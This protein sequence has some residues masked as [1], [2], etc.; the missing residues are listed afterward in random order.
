MSTDTPPDSARQIAMSLQEA[1]RLRAAGKAGEAE[2]LC[3][4]LLARHPANANI[5]NSLALLVW[6]RGEMNE[7]EVLFRAAIATAPQQAALYNNLGGL[8]HK[9]GD[10]PGAEFAFRTAIALKPIYPEACYNLGLVLHELG[11]APEA[12]AAQRRAVALNP[13]YGEALVRI[14]AL[15]SEAGRNEEA[16]RALDRALALDRTSF[17]AHYYRGSVLTALERYEEA[18]LALNAALALRPDSHQAHHAY[19]NAL[20]RAGRESEALESYRKALDAAPEFLEAHRDYNALAWTM[21]RHDL[22]LKSYALARARA[23]ETPDLLLAEADQRLRHEEGAVAERLLCQAHEAAPERL[24]ITNALA[25]ALTMQGHFG[26]SIALLENATKIAPNAIYNHRDLA[27][28]FLQDGQPAQAR[29][30]LEEALALAP[31]DQLILAF[32]TLAYREL[33]DSNLDRLI[34]VDKYVRVYDLPPPSGYVDAESFNRALGEDLLGLHTSQ[35]E[36]FD[37]TLRGGT[38]TPGFLFDRPTRAIGAIQERISEAVAD[39]VGRFPDDPTHPLLARKDKDFSFSG[40]WSCRLR[41]SGFHTNHVHPEGWISSAYYVA[42][43]DAVGDASA[44]QGWLKFGESNLALGARD[45]PGRVI[46]PGIGK[47]VLFPS[48]FWHGTVPFRSDDM[49]LTIAF[50]VIPGKP[51][52]QAGPG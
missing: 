27:I 16:L 43:P 47:L 49:R 10:L 4:E 14:G 24:D 22:N 30:V 11:F 3:R 6:D 52:G 28:A 44:R 32:L 51:A 1:D 31:F 41:S 39:Y 35:V 33:G 48:Y 37:Q 15:L 8:Q 19:G 40:A 45:Q 9:R 7:A 26:D 2:R 18:L 29:R 5:L 50:D 13:R 21:G 36:P 25:R 23:G 42:L 38:Q 46:K 17:E 12:L 34:D 20:V